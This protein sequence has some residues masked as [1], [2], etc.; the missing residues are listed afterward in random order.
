MRQWR[1]YEFRL[2]LARSFNS[3]SAARRSKGQLCIAAIRR[4]HFEPTS[5]AI[6]FRSHQLIQAALH[7]MIFHR[8]EAEW[9]T[10]TAFIIAGGPSVLNYDLEM[11]RGRN[12]IVI[13]SSIHAVPWANFLYFGDW[14]WWNEPE[15][16]AAVECFPG[17]VITTSR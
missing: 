17:R 11:L 14:R 16:R 4:W 1:S 13:N 8:I 12:V 5:N 15:N 9:A 7:R 6:R 2:W 10:E 3:G